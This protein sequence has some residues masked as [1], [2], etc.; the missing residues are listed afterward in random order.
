MDVSNASVYDG[1]TAA[2]EAVSMCRDRGKT[3]VL[4]TTG[5]NPYYI[6]V[7]KTYCAPHGMTVEIIPE[8][9]GT[10]DLAAFK[11]SGG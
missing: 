9:D 10:V 8:K 1:A 7:V 5:L 2:A 11:N 4:L 6:D 3:K